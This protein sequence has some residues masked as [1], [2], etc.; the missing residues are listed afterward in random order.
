[1]TPERLKL[2]YLYKITMRDVSIGV[3]LT[4]LLAALKRTTVGFSSDHADLRWCVTF[5]LNDGT[6]R[7]VY[8]DGFGRRGQIDNLRATFHGGIYD[9]L[10]QLTAPLK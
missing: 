5:R 1:M 6:I 10:R 4:A 8:L 7:E 9:W 2:E 3:P